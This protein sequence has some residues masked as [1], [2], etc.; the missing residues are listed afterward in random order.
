MW[1]I[2]LERKF[3][4]PRRNKK[5]SYLDYLSK[6][7]WAN[8]MLTSVQELFTFVKLLRKCKQFWQHFDKSKTTSQIW[9]KYRIHI[10]FIK[11]ETICFGF[12]LC[13]FAQIHCPLEEYRYLLLGNLFFIDAELFVLNLAIP[14]RCLYS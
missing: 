1:I 4:T 2:L 12:I 14:I 7:C 6:T 11:C 8:K 3:G 5:N 9:F 10:F 13:V